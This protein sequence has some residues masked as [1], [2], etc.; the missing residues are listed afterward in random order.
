MA[1]GNSMAH[2][3]CQH[4][5]T[6]HETLQCECD[7][8]RHEMQFNGTVLTCDPPLYVHKCPNCG[9]FEHTP[10]LFPR[11]SYKPLETSERVPLT[12]K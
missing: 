11:V 9:T 4:V 1:T 12:G 7:N 5:Q 10:A 8:G 6:V 3:F 2:I